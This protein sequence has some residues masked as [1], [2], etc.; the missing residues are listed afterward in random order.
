MLIV[1]GA[2]EKKLMWMC[3]RWLH[4]YNVNLHKLLTMN[5]TLLL[6]VHIQTMLFLSEMHCGTKY[7]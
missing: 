2:E 7:M 4:Y 5:Y 3:F 1:T 6:Y